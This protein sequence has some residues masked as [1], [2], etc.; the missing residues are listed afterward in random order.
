MGGDGRG[1]PKQCL[2]GASSIV[3]LLDMVPPHLHIGALLHPGQMPGAEA[4]L[5]VAK[6]A[7]HW[8][9][10]VGWGWAIVG[11]AQECVEVG[12]G[13]GGMVGHQWGNM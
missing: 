5:V 3:Q 7:S 8:V 13:V 9:V 1:G 2:G 10:Q 11:P 6:V 12:I 4:K